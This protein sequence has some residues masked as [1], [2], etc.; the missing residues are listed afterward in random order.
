MFK[1]LRKVWVDGYMTWVDKINRDIEI[2]ESNIITLDDAKLV[3]ENRIK[4][5]ELY[6]LREKLEG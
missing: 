1:K 6:K 3:E 5:I 4:L 2:A